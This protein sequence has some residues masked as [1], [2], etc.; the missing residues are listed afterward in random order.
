[1][2][3]ICHNVERIFHP[4]FSTRQVE[5]LRGNCLRQ[6]KLTFHFPQLFVKSIL[7][8]GAGRFQSDLGGMK[9]PILGPGF[10]N[11]QETDWSGVHGSLLESGPGFWTPPRQTGVR[12]APPRQTGV[13]RAPP[14]QTGGQ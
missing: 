7:G 12:R 14:R 2:V 5:G 3:A 8:P 11:G 4:G 1:N 6:K 10:G 13:R 9:S